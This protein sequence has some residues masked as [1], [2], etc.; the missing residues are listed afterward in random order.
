MI[1]NLRLSL[2]LRNLGREFS[3]ITS[4]F[5]LVKSRP[6][7]ESKKEPEELEPSGKWRD[8]KIST[9]ESRKENQPEKQRRI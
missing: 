6:F 9:L 8:N 7:P 2:D 1:Q 3:L 4:V 5:L